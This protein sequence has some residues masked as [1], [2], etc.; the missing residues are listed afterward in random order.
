MRRLLL[1]G[2]LLWKRL[3]EFLDGRFALLVSAA[4]VF[5]LFYFFGAL[6]DIVD[7][8]GFV[9]GHE[10][11]QAMLRDNFG[12]QCAVRILHDK[13]TAQTFI[14]SVHVHVGCSFA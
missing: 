11:H 8:R 14:A 2:G 4:L 6:E 5:F 12:I 10:L 13:S 7:G 3:E 9:R 1:D